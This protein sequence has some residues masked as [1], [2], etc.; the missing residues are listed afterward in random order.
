MG[1][2][3][4]RT[5]KALPVGGLGGPYGGE[6][7]RPPHLLDNQFTDAGKFVNLT[8]RLPFIP[9]KIPDTHFCHMLG[10]S[11]GNSATGRIRSIE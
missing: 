7:S 4:R 6:M 11:Q 9:R 2:I 5:G 8:R 3:N 10:R 1:C